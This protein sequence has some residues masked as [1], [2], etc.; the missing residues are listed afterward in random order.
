MDLPSFARD[1]VRKRNTFPALVMWSPIVADKLR[2]S[3]LEQKAAA[4][5]AK[6][7]K[8][9]GRDIERAAKLNPGRDEAPLALKDILAAVKCRSVLHQL[10]PGPGV[11]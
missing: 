3:N 9:R 5:R 11:R 7:L 8:Q 10:F 6:Y 4:A 2:I 1:A